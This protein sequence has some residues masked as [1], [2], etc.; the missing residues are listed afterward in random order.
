[1]SYT[2]TTSEGFFSRLG[3]SIGGIFVGIILI[4]A[5]SALL[6]WNE[7]RYV[8]EAAG[9]SEGKGSVQEIK[10][11]KVDPAMEGKL[12]HLTG[13]TKA[14]S[15]LEDSAF[16]V[17][18]KAIRLRRNVQFF[19]WVEKK[20]S[21]KRKKLG[22]GEETVNTYTYEKKWVDRHEDSSDFKEKGHVNP[23]PPDIDKK[24]FASSDATI[25]AYKLQGPV[26]EDLDQFDKLPLANVHVPADK[27]FKLTNDVLYQGKD[28]ATPAVGD[29][30][31]DFQVVN[32]GQISLV[33]RQTGDSFDT[34]T[35][36]ADTKILLVESGAHTASEMLKHAEESNSMMTWVLR[37]VGWL[38]MCI[39][40]SMLVGP[41][42]IVADII[43]FF[44]DLVGLG[45]GLFGFAM[46]SSLALVCIAIGWIFA[47]PLVGILMLAGAIGI[48]VMLKKA[49][50]K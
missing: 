23:A 40:F 46:G 36:K 7:G 44:G 39:G 12:V 37:F 18:A 24:D 47:R 6:Y 49:G 21:K 19:E 13:T 11:D 16:G 29:V 43:P 3:N 34:Y 42:N 27:K 2:E 14:S 48:F 4:L 20:E 35:T 26:L 38:L 25:G 32:P 15:A 50:K 45:T 5:S 22:G 30:K 28:P 8:R 9:L 10:E 1:M 41:I 33:A 17:S 31:V